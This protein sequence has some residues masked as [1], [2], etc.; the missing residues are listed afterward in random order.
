VLAGSHELYVICLDRKTGE[1]I[2]DKVLGYSD[3]SRG[4]VSAGYRNTETIIKNNLDVTDS[5]DVV[6]SW[7]EGN[8]GAT[9]VV[10]RLSGTDGS[11]QDK[12]HI[13]ANGSYIE[14]LCIDGNGA[15]V[16]GNSSAIII[17]LDP[18]DYST[19]DYQVD[20]SGHNGAMRR[21]GSS[22]KVIYA[23]GGGQ[24]ATSHKGGFVILN[25]DLTVDSSQYYN[26]DPSNFVIGMDG[27]GFL[28]RSIGA[29]DAGNIFMWGT[30]GAWSSYYEYYGYNAILVKANSAGTIQWSNHI[31]SLSS[32]NPTHIAATDMLPTP[33]GTKVVVFD[34]IASPS[35]SHNLIIYDGSDGSDESGYQIQYAGAPSGTGNDTPYHGALA[36]DNSFAYIF[37]IAGDPGVKTNL[38]V[39]KLPLEGMS[40][41]NTALLN[42]NE[43][44]K[45]TTTNWA[46]GSYVLT[47]GSGSPSPYSCS[48]SANGTD[49]VQT[50]AQTNVSNT[51]R[52]M[53]DA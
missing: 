38:H 48:Y 53:S 19:I 15:P 9:A 20:Y 47:T 34:T 29:D 14:G 28:C 23:G 7:V 36:V 1:V 4:I 41:S 26:L 8:A 35:D 2:W 12:V 27:Y 49:T 3:G 40:A 13:P 32:S 51:L 50:A 11:I 18:T 52:D 44:I 16:V 39:L 46:E 24:D 22:G 5:G 45:I 10:V 21:Y 43:E 33:D 17:K 30:G 6:C 31:T 37:S 25:D 42:Y